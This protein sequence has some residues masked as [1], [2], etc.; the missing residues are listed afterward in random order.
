MVSVP[1]P[2]M[3]SLRVDREIEQHLFDLSAVGA[4]ARQRRVAFD[5]EL[6]V[7]ADDAT[8]HRT[9]AVHHLT[10]IEHRRLENLLPAE[11]E[12]LMGEIRRA[13][14]RVDHLTQV[15]GGRAV[16]LGAHQRQLACS[17]R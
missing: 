17:R 11:G 9:D 3:A 5:V 6:N 2:G 8:Q 13:I 10:E 7:L 14:R 12:Q 15:V 16:L 1:P 4:D